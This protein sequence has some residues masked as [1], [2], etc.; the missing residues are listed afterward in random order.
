[1][2]QCPADC[3]DITQI[4]NIAECE[5]NP[6]LDNIDRLMLFN[7]DVELPE[8][9]TCAALETLKDAGQLTFT[10]PL[11]TVDLQDPEYA[12]LSISDC[13]PAAELVSGRTMS[14]QD[15]VAI[16][17]PA[18]IAVSPAVTAQP[19]YNQVFW[20][21][22]LSIQQSLRYAIVKCSGKV[23]IAKDPSTGNYLTAT[24]RAFMKQENIGSAASPRWIE[25]VQGQVN[26]KGDPLA[27]ANLPEELADHTNFDI[28]ECDLY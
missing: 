23:V 24:L 22:K 4:D 7:C 8:P 9:L 16:D 15:K 19:Y 1:M 20:A 18:N 26:F 3:A 11:S 5:L 10:S 14:F 27:P 6:R 28:S 21:D 12:E 17:R 25:Y 2:P 13:L